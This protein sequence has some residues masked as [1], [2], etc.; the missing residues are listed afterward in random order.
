[1]IEEVLKGTEKIAR[2]S[3]AVRVGGGLGVPRL[4]D[5]A[6]DDVECWQLKLGPALVNEA[7]HRLDDVLVHADA[8]HGCF[9][10]VV[11]LCLADRETDVVEGGQ[12][13]VETLHG[14]QV[15]LLARE[16][17]RARVHAFDRSVGQSLMVIVVVVRINRII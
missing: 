15:R 4:T 3:R 11:D 8:R 1:M 6:V 12:F 13:G 14:L 16:G 5:D 7:L 9:C 17:H 10:D 2:K